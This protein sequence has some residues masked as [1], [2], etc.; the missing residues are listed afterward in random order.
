M[1]AA[2]ASTPNG[3][4]PNSGGGAA[5]RPGVTQLNLVATATW[6][7]VPPTPEGVRPWSPQQR[8]VLATDGLTYLGTDAK[9]RPVVEGLA[10]IPNTLRTWAVLRNGDPTD[11]TQPVQLAHRL[12][13]PEA[14]PMRRYRVTLDVEYL[15]PDEQVAGELLDD[16]VRGANQVGQVADYT[17]PELVR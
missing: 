7:G 10:G 13:K 2:L 4:P 17:G 16:L 14:E 3:P 15:A 5:S 8:L 12:P 11:V 9:T 6:V 1:M